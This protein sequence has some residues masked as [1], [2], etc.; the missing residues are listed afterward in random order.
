[1][2]TLDELITIAAEQRAADKARRNAVPLKCFQDF[3]EGRLLTDLRYALGE[4]TYT[5]KCQT[6]L[7]IC[8]AAFTDDRGQEWHLGGMFDDDDGITSISLIATWLAPM[9]AHYSMRLDRNDLTT[10]LLLA[11]KTVRDYD[12]KRRADLQQRLDER[13]AK[14][15]EQEAARAKFDADQLVADTL[16]AQVIERAIEALASNQPIERPFHIY[17]WSW[18]ILPLIDRDD[19]DFAVGHGY[20]DQ[21]YSLQF[22]VDKDGWI[23]LQPTNINHT[24]T[25]EIILRPEHL[26][27]VER[28]TIRSWSDLPDDLK[29]TCY[30]MMPDGWTKNYNAIPG[31]GYGWQQQPGQTYHRLPLPEVQPLA[32]VRQLAYGHPGQVCVCGKDGTLWNGAWMCWDCIKTSSDEMPF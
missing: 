13:A 28:L 3:L 11:I 15:A 1:M 4:L 30:A 6:G 26:A 2:P 31:R 7:D 25:Q 18:V 8:T 9:D 10:S 16:T 20:R 14:L 23:V 24:V 12:D 32:W 27:I 22:A 21:G 19:D 29:D 5:Y 17:R